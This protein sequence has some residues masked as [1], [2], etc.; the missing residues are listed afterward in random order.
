LSKKNAGKKLAVW[1]FEVL[2]AAKSLPGGRGMLG[3][4]I[5]KGEGRPVEQ[6]DS[7]GTRGISAELTK[8]QEHWDDIDCLVQG[9][10]GR[11]IANDMIGVYQENET[12]YKQYIVAMAGRSVVGNKD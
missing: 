10:I 9:I 11:K 7:S 8:K 3:Q 12:A 4:K 6:T 5:L 1:K 2:V